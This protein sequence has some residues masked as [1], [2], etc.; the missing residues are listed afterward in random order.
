MS[1]S[2]T[3]EERDFYIA[4]AAKEH[5]SKRELERQLDSAYY[6][7]YVLSSGKQPPELVP[8]AHLRTGGGIRPLGVDEELIPEASEGEHSNIG[9]IFF[10]LG[11]TL[12]MVLDVALG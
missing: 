7:R 10:A 8:H 2:K 3:K 1:K 4:L 5:Y 6:E 9:T 12:M 11:F